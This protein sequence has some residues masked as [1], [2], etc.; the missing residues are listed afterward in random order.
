MRTPAHSGK[1]PYVRYHKAP[2]VYQFKRCNHRKADGRPAAVY[3]QTA[4]WHGDVCSMCNT[5]L[6]NFVRSRD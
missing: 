2:Y 5:I 4:N 6:K 3:Q 1:S